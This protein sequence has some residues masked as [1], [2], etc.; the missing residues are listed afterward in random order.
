M[1]HS[2]TRSLLSRRDVIIVASVSLHLRYRLGRVVP[3]HADRAARRARA[4]GATC[5][6]GSWSTS[7]TSATTS[8]STAA[9]SACAATWSRCSRPTRTSAR[10]ASSSSATRSS[11]S[12]RSIRCAARCCNELDKYGIYPGSHYVTPARA[13]HA[14]DRRR[15]ARSSRERLEELDARQQA[16][17][18]A[19]PRA[20]H[21]VRPRDARADGLLPR[22]RE[23][24]APLLEPQAGRSAAHADRLLSRRLPAGDRRVAPDACRRSAPCTA[25]TARAK[26]RWSSTAFACPARSTTA[27]C[28]FEEFETH[29]KQAHLRQRDAGRLGAASRR[30]GVIVEQVIRPTGLMDPVIHVRPVGNQV[31]DLLGEIRTRVERRA[32][33]CWSPR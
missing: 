21:A 17:R 29:I 13:A 7:S 30:Q 25:A 27:R 8:T 12:A 33:A 26:R 14:R 22:H 28:K 1:R 16:A 3:G 20:A 23:L 19:A 4:F 5:C 31:D 6:C 9:R 2:A 10:C 18:E 15:S 11:A 24:L 32:S